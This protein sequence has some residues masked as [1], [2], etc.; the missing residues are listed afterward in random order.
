MNYV[1]ISD[2][3]KP[4]T[5]RQEDT[6]CPLNIEYKLQKLVDIPELEPLSPEVLRTPDP[7]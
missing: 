7:K 5:Y 4:D 3:E 1:R 2:L 6:P